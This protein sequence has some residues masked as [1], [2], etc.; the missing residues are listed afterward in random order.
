MYLVFRKVYL[1]LIYED[2]ALVA[3]LAYAPALGAGARKGL[4]VQISPKAP[5]YKKA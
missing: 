3:E 1:R 5:K 2:L 4:R